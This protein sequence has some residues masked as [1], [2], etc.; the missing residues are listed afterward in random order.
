MGAGR[1]FPPQTPR[2]K[3]CSV[4]LRRLLSASTVVLAVLA[5][6]LSPFV[7]AWPASKY[8]VLHAFGAG[9]DGGGLWGSLVRDSRGNLYGTTSGGGTYGQG[10][11]FELR[12]GSNGRWSETVLH[13]FPS[14]SDDG[15]GPTS[16]LIVDAAGNLYGTTRGGGG[17]YKVGTIFELT[18]QSKGSWTESILYSFGTHSNDAYAP[19][20]GLVI[21]DVGNL[22]GTGHSVFELLPDS[23]NWREKVIHRFTSQHDG[24]GPF[25]GVILDAAGNLY[26]TTEGGGTHEYG[27][28]YMVQ[29]TS[30]GWKEQVLHNFPAFPQ[31]GQVPGVGALVI[32]GSGSLYGTTDVGG[33]FRYGT[34][35]RLTL[36]SDGRWKETILHGFK[37]DVDGYE[38][39][40]GVVRDHAGNLYGTTI[41]GG[42]P[43][44]D[45]GVVYKLAPTAKGKWTY[46]VLHTFSGYDGAQPDAN[47][48][49]DS[50]G[51]L[52]GTTATGGANGGGV[53]FELTP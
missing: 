20:A 25:A 27:T 53:V 40:A 34:V 43:Q 47:L 21:D 33:A 28:V 44:C 31:D 46:T 24:D 15:Q 38:P 26:G 41:A 35:F 18:P 16:N 7:G 36:G 19:Y 48:I 17:P 29:H 11:V 22:Y 10:T 13:D 32:D 39:S 51:N 30:S 2:P 50:Q 42:S 4:Q 45:C 52:Y 49:L 6:T 9:K 1:S 12:S 23:G 3:V 8:K 5:I 14:S 37:P